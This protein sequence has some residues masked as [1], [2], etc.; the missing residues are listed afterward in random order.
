M[1]QRKSWLARQC[2]NALA[3]LMFPVLLSLVYWVDQRWTVV[4]TFRITSQ[5]VTPEG[6]VIE[7]M[8]D[9]RRDCHFVEVVSVSDDVT[10]PVVFLNHPR[11]YTYS[12]PTGPQKFGPW[13]VTADDKSGVKLYARHRCHAGWEHMAELTSFV[14]GTQ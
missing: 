2:A 14:V 6:V 10:H 8:M 9:K 11:H 5:F 7:G 1:T 12:R 3:F 13:L 4:D